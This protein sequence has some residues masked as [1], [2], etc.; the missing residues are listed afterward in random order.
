M[1]QFVTLVRRYTSVIVSDKG[2]LALM[3][4]LP[5]VLGAVSLLIDADKGPAAQSRQPAD[6]PD[7]SQR[8]RH[9]GCC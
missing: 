9:H 1:S 7:H 4:I 2:F 5:A 3:V 6:R 8:H